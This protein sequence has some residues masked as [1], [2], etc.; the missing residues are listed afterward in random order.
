MRDQELQQLHGPPVVD[1]LPLRDGGHG[2]VRVLLEVLGVQ[3][4]VVEVALDQDSGDDVA[5][6]G[7]GHGKAADDLLG[8]KCTIS[9]HFLRRNE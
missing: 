9:V 3:D 7:P 6:G 5:L 4:V 2:H 8:F 1:R